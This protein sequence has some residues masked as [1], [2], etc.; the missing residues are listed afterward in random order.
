VTEP[1]ASQRSLNPYKQLAF[2]ALVVVAFVPSWIAALS[3]RP[4]FLLGEPAGQTP[5]VE[6]PESPPVVPIFEDRLVYTHRLTRFA[7]SPTLTEA[8]NGDLLVVWFGGTGEGRPSIGLYQSTYRPRV[9]VWTPPRLVTDRDQTRAELGRY[10]FTIGNPT[11]WTAPEGD[12]YLF[13]V[14]SWAAGWSGSSVS[15]KISRDHADTWSPAQRL[16]VSPFFNSGT[17]VRNT[18][19]PYSD[20]TIGVPAYHELFGVFPELLRVNRE[21]VAL[22]KVRID[23]GRRS[24]QPSI[25]VLNE[26]RAL[27]LLR[28]RPREERAAR[29]LRAETN[30]AGQSWSQPTPLDLLN[31]GSSVVGLRLSDGSI[32]AATNSSTTSRND[33]SLARSLDAGESWNVVTAIEHSEQGQQF[34]YPTLLQATDGRIHLAYAWDYARIKHVEFNTAWLDTRDP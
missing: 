27:A 30:D 3:A 17:L 16:V 6:A 25:V 23:Y 26:N 32:L 9:G 33:L 11:L 19:F 2:A 15:L 22:G 13:Y 28:P 10:V 4:R 1:G 34:A 24:L 31:P 21:G 8:A 29:V 5:I 14:T 12:L 18:P 7:H 20:G